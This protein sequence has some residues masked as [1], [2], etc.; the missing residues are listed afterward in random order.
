MKSFRDYVQ[1]REEDNPMGLAA[2]DVAGPKRDG[3]STPDHEAYINRLVQVAKTAVQ[4]YPEMMVDLLGKVA[5]KDEGIRASLEAV[6]GETKKFG[7]KAFRDKGLG[8][9]GY[10]DDADQVMPNHADS[11]SGD[12]YEG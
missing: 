3:P 8:Q 12:E 2:K 5:E 6:R 7:G 10:D 9:M 1:L 4:K 11:H